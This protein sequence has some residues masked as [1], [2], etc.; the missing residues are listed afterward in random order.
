MKIAFCRLCATVFGR[1]GENEFSILSFC[2]NIWYNLYTDVFLKR[3]RAAGDFPA[4]P[5]FL[6]GGF[7]R[8]ARSWAA[9]RDGMLAGKEKDCHESLLSCH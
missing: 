7:W 4:A 8:E 6:R 3:L 1:F 9:D 5:V 2:Q